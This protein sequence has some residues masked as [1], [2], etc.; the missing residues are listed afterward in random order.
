MVTKKGTKLCKPALS[1]RTY[2]YQQEVR[3]TDSTCLYRKCVHSFCNSC[4]CI[5]NTVDIPKGGHIHFVLCLMYQSLLLKLHFAFEFAS[6]G[7][8][9]TLVS[10][11][12]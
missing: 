8:Y 11:E 4:Q 2:G 10:E 3:F 9:Q 5:D 7:F 1:I 12:G 6:V